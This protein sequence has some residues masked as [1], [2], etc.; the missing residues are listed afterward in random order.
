M[1]GSHVRV[2]SLEHMKKICSDGE[3]KDFV[4]LMKH[5]LRSSKTISYDP[6]RKK[7]WGVF[8]L[9]DDSEQNLTDRT[10]FKNTNIGDAI[11]VG[12]FYYEPY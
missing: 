9:I 7:P 2:E 6:S 3:P 10:L 8:N 1:T 12:A 11:Q 4:L 5:S